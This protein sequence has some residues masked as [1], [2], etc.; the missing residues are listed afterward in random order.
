[1]RLSILLLS[2]LVVL[3]VL[4]SCEAKKKKVPGPC[5]VKDCKKCN[6]TGKKCKVCNTGFKPKQRGKKCGPKPCFVNPCQNGGE[7]KY[8]KKKKAEICTCPDGFSGNVCEIKAFDPCDPNPCQNG[9]SCKNGDCK[10]PAGFLG[11]KCQTKDP[12]SPNP[13]Q[14]GGKC[15]GGSCTCPDGFLG[16][17]CETKDPCKPN[18]C[19]NGGSCSDGAC[20]CAKGFSGSNCEDE[21]PEPVLSIPDATRLVKGKSVGTLATIFKTYE[22][23]LDVK[24]DS[25]QNA[26]QSV[27]HV[28]GTGGNCCGYGDRTPGIWF[29]ASG[30]SQSKLHICAPVNSNGNAC[31]NSANYQ[32][33]QWINIKVTQKLMYGGAYKYWIELDGVEV[34]TWDNN[35]P[36]QWNNA[37]VY[38]S[39]PWYVQLNG[40]VR[41]LKIITPLDPEPAPPS[42]VVLSKPGESTLTKGSLAGTIS[43][44]HKTYSVSLDIYANSFVN[45]WQSIIHV[46][47]TGG[48]CCGYGDRTPGLWFHGSANS[49]SK[50]H[51]CSAVNGN[52]NACYNSGS[53][54]VGTWFNVKVTQQLIKGV[55]KYWIDIDGNKVHEWDNSQAREFNDVKVYLT[56]P[57]YHNLNGKVR[58]LEIVTPLDPPPPVQAV[59]VLNRASEAALGKGSLCGTINIEQ[60]YSVELEVK[61]NSFVN[62]WQSIIHFTGTGGNCCGYGDR[63]PGLWF[64]ASGSSSSKLHIC[65]AVSNNGNHCYNS[66][67]FNTGSWISI[68]ITQAFV[69]GA[70]PYTIDIN[71]AQ[72]YST[73]NSNAKAYPNTKVYC[74]DPWYHQLNGSIRNLK[75]TS[76]LA[77]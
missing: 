76:P 60:T 44:L 47:G 45:A 74:A 75:V 77:E 53:F 2:V 52:G 27:L 5:K 4:A 3:A 69:N 10:C 40:E 72:V 17:N 57:W 48:N 58:N 14:N 16:D 65:S 39:D 8:N 71:G 43:K 9:G 50:L 68:K 35:N 64:W 6:I 42:E 19:Q 31:Y 61:A 29:W 15:D 62:A 1:M 21:G 32:V 38:L 54:N 13:C 23:S 11:D 63:T 33:G 67:N 28:T 7:C 51:I 66:A 37:N 22:V 70:Y 36:Q 26:W 24:V 34:H 55:Y 49:Q 25:F 18:P 73:T 46:T 12:C 56:D 59:E 30:S 20:T 41:N